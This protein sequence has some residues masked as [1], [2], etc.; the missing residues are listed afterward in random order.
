MT[1]Y[2]RHLFEPGRQEPKDDHQAAVEAVSRLLD[3][4]QATLG[5]STEVDALSVPDA[6]RLTPE[7]R[8]NVTTLFRHFRTRPELVFALDGQHRLTAV[9]WS[10]LSHSSRWLH[11]P[12]SEF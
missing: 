11:C 10:R 7:V 6:D 2:S 3:N 9:H 12:H 1:Q 5:H 4:V 8:D